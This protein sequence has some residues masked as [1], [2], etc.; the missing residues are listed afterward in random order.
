VLVV[1]QVEAPILAMIKE[2]TKAE[3][4]EAPSPNRGAPF[5]LAW[6]T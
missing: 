5:F 4:P 3:E 1:L 2:E 6:F